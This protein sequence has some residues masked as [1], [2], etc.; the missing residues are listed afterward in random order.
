MGK[1]IKKSFFS[2]LRWKT[3]RQN[4]TNSVVPLNTTYGFADAA[5]VFCAGG[6]LLAFVLNNVE[7]EINFLYAVYVTAPTA[8]T[9]AVFA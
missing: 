3:L 2:N 5:C 4:N 6:G 9:N 8:A 7:K 1:Y